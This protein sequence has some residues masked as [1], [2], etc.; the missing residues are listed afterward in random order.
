LVKKIEEKRSEEPIQQR[1]ETMV[2]FLQRKECYSLS[3]A[4]QGSETVDAAALL[5]SLARFIGP[6]DP[7]WLSTLKAIEEDLVSDSLVYR[8]KSS[9]QSKERLF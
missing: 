6:K 7:R 2:E 3:P 8:Y 1:N 9:D 4:D 5:M